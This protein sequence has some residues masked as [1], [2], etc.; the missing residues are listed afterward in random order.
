LKPLWPFYDP[1]NSGE[2]VNYTAVAK[3]FGCNQTTLSKQYRGVQ[4]SKKDQY[5]KLQLLNPQQ[6]DVLLKYINT[7]CKQALSPSKEIIRNFAR[8]ISE[9]DIK[10]H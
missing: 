10:K 8:E 9:N 5:E 4:G 1:W 6:E 7:L 3:N 2:S